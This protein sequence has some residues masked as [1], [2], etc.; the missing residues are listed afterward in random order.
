[1]TAT[2]VLEGVLRNEGADVSA[3]DAFARELASRDTIPA[4]LAEYNSIASH[5]AP[6]RWNGL[7][8]GAGLTGDQLADVKSSDAYG[9]LSAALRTADAVG[10]E[11]DELVAAVVSSRALDDADDLAS[12]LHYRVQR[13]LDASGY[14]SAASAGNADLVAGLFPRV[15]A[16]DDED[17]ARALLERDVAIETR[18]RSLAA[19]DVAEGAA[20]TQPFGPAPVD[21]DTYGDWLESVATVAAYRERWGIESAEP[22][23]T[24]V[25]DHNI[26]QLGHYRRASA[27]YESALA[28]ESAAPE[29]YVLAGDVDLAAEVESAGPDFSL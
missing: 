11:V 8:L 7:L 16:V 28:V 12:V 1:V 18:A 25:D 17:L 20:W 13:Y 3:T 26:T 9:P 4:L 10:A 22:L 23:G 21:P 29:Q 24:S 27:A 14:A 5:A 6:E 15:G 19:R 2:E